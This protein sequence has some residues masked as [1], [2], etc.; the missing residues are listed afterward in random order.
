MIGYR[1]LDFST[2]NGRLRGVGSGGEASSRGLGCWVIVRALGA[3]GCVACL[4]TGNVGDPGVLMGVSP[5]GL[6]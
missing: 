1:K 4:A 6:E 2:G 3:S 5:V